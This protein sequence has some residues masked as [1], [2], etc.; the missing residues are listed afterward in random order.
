MCFVELKT[1][2]TVQEIMCKL[3]DHELGELRTRQFWRKAE[4]LKMQAKVG[5]I[6]EQFWEGSFPMALSH[7]VFIRITIWSELK[8]RGSLKHL[9]KCLSSS[10]PKLL[11]SW[12]HVQYINRHRNTNASSIC[13]LLTVHF[14]CHYFLR[15][16]SISDETG[17]CFIYGSYSLLT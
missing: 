8:M 10:E 1:Y 6:T 4:H 16:R 17:T 7:P 9:R 15:K 14:F 11:V 12:L 13:N 3:N 5:Q 2:R